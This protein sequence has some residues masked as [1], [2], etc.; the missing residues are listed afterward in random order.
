MDEQVKH[1]KNEAAGLAFTAYWESMEEGLRAAGL[2]VAESL[3]ETVHSHDALLV[4]DDG[5]PLLYVKCTWEFY[6]HP[7]VLASKLD[8]AQKS[9]EE[10]VITK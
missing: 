4:G 7:A 5:R 3:N 10:E 6:A 1:I 9:K 8:Q 2:P